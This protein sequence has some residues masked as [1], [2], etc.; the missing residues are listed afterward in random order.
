MRFHS[1]VQLPAKFKIFDFKNGYDKNKL[2]GVYGV[3]RYDE[4]RSGMYTSELFGPASGDARTIHMGIDIGAP[5]GTAVFAFTDG[6]VFLS[7][8]NDRPGDYGGT[9]ITQHRL[10][11]KNLWALHGHLAH[12]SLMNLKPGAPIRMGQ[13]IATIGSEKEN[14]GWNPH[15]HFQ[16]SWIKP[17]CCD[18]PG[19]VSMKDRAQAL[20]DFPD[21]RLVLGP[22]Y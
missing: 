13:Q 11:N 1:V 19:V 18:M 9:L 14:G 16:L 17:D 7:G 2:R 10:E 12:E 15:L 20:L 6:E 8:I 4:D 22:I 5:E 21:P 3:G